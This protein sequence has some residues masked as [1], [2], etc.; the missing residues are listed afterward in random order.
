[1]S[2]TGPLDDLKL[3]RVQVVE[4]TAGP[5]QIWVYE[6]GLLRCKVL[7]FDRLFRSDSVLEWFWLWLCS[8]IMT[9]TSLAFSLQMVEDCCVETSGGV[10]MAGG[11]LNISP[12]PGKDNQ[13]W[14]IT[15]DG[16]IRNNL[17]PDLVLEVKGQYFI[18]LNKRKDMKWNRIVGVEQ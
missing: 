1:M 7:D 13:F 4:E 14:S 11:R 15:G 6:N 3:L 8:L 2:L 9:T 17:K 10:V 5:E 16:I 18:H 12:E